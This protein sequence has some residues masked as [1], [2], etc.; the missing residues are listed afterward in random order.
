MQQLRGELIGLYHVKRFGSVKLLHGCLV[1]DI[2]WMTGGNRAS[3]VAINSVISI[4]G[5]VFLPFYCNESL[6]LN[7]IKKEALSSLQRCYETEKKYRDI[8]L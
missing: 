4:H 1:W 5:V 8:F 7:I 6:S 3:A 2:A